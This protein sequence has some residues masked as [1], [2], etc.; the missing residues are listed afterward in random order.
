MGLYSF[1]SLQSKLV[2]WITFCGSEIKMLLLFSIDGD[3]HFQNANEFATKVLW[4]IWAPQ[5][6]PCLN[7]TKLCALCWLWSLAPTNT[8]LFP[9]CNSANCCAVF[10]HPCWPR[11]RWRCQQKCWRCAALWCSPEDCWTTAIICSKR[12]GHIFINRIIF[13]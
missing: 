13:I 1:G 11:P 3:Q 6:S 12:H 8:T 10:L 9:L 7:E 4:Q 5:R 2:W